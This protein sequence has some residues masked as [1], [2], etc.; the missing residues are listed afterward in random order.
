[1]P[2][3]VFSL[4][5]IGWIPACVHKRIAPM[6]RS[7]EAKCIALGS[8]SCLFF[9]EGGRAFVEAGEAVVLEMLP[10]DAGLGVNSV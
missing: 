4:S 5:P 9:P 2:S 6:N 3:F 7:N 10:G 8:L 1:M